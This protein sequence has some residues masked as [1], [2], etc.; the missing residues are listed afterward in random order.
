MRAFVCFLPV[1][2][3]S[4]LVNAATMVP[5]AVGHRSGSTAL[6]P[7]NADA[8]AAGAALARV[9]DYVIAGG[10]N[11][12]R[13]FMVIDKRRARLFVLSSQGRIEAESPILLGA[14]R[15]DFSAAGIGERNLSDILPHEKTTP[16]GWFYARPGTNLAGEDILWLD[17]DAAV[18]IHRVRAT[19]PAERRLERLASETPADNRI[20]FGCINVPKDFYE[21]WLRAGRGGDGVWVYVIPETMPFETFVAGR[22]PEVLR[23]AA[24]SR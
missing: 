4:M 1:V 12:Q 8:G 11:E 24:G 21:R 15:G 2:A 10:H 3:A 19:N 17:Y 18:S 16:A 7:I 13:P 20:S 22:A 5:A 9:R 6:Q 23:E 14:A